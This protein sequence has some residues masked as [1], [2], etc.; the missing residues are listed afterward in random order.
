MGDLIIL[1]IGANMVGIA[2]K[3]VGLDRLIAD[4]FLEN[5]GG[6][7][8]PL[9]LLAIMTFTMALSVVMSAVACSVVM[10]E[11]GVKLLERLDE[12]ILIDD[13]DYPEAKTGERKSSLLPSYNSS[14]RQHSTI[15]SEHS[16][17]MSEE[18]GRRRPTSF[19]EG[20]LWPEREGNPIRVFGKGLLIAIPYATTLGGLMSKNGTG[21]NLVFQVIYAELTGGLEVDWG[22]W[23]LYCFP[24]SVIL[25]LLLWKLF[26]YLFVLPGLDTTQHTVLDKRGRS[27]GGDLNANDNQ[28][29]TNRAAWIVGGDLLLLIML[30]ILRNPDWGGVQGWSELFPEAGFIG[31]G[32]AALLC[33]FLL[34]CVPMDHSQ[35]NILTWQYMSENIPWGVFFL[36][37]G[38]TAL[39]TIMIESGLTDIVG[40]CD[41][42]RARLRV[43]RLCCWA[44]AFSDGNFLLI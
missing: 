44:C 13:S 43:G 17:T 35:E 4:A 25:L 31:D 1:L 9:L 29:S 24:T 6:Q 27:N 34:Y 11:V 2:M 26:C 33:A 20:F 23:F 3:R 42:R 37:G 30:W 39:S 32:T 5:V 18:I 38:G 28:G 14:Q 8:P 7:G 22:R 40:A 21:Q 16:T 41:V 19:F 15:T 36:V 12:Q 10:C